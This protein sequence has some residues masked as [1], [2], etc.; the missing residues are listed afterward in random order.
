MPQASTWVS[1]TT[2]EPPA[3]SYLV[4]WGNPHTALGSLHYPLPGIVSSRRL[5]VAGLR[6]VSCFLSLC[7]LMAS[8]AKLKRLRLEADIK[9]TGTEMPPCTRCR[10]AKVKSGDPRPKCIVGPKSGRCSECVR[11]GY[12]KD[13]DVKLSVP[14]WERFRDTR[15]RLSKELEAADEEELRLLMEQQDV[16]RK[17]STHKAKKI[18]LRKQLRLAEN[19]TE[20]A[21]TRELD[22]LEM[23]E[24]VEE[25]FLPSVE[26][27]GV[28]VSG[29]PNEADPWGMSPSDWI[30]LC[31][32]SFPL[33]GLESYGSQL[34]TSGAVSE[35]IPQLASAN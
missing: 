24:A 7:L 20:T 26:P 3:P 8:A 2:S 25:E 13:C 14:E 28:E 19:R 18:R 17:L 34:G 16:L 12:H 29:P 6:H 9:A 1:P 11:K 4:T 21:I 27:T 5:S 10:T 32:P 35:E 30:G 31:D 33:E 23:A 15:E 22:E